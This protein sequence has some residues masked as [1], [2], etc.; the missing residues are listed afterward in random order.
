MSSINN[1]FTFNYQQPNEYHFSHDSVF[2]ARKAFEYVQSNYT[3]Y[4]QVLDLCAGCGVV[5]LDFFF[6]ISCSKTLSQ[7]ACQIH[8]CL[9]NDNVLQIQVFK[10]ETLFHSVALFLYSVIELISKSL[11]PALSFLCRLV[12]IF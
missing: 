7:S 6:H 4:D 1:F 9:C 8:V 5:G 10:V 3:S 12:L 11:F 2:L